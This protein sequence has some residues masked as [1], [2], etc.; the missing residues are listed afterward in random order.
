M[1]LRSLAERPFPLNHTLSIPLSD[2]RQAITR[3]SQRSETAHFLRSST[4]ASTEMRETRKLSNSDLE[5]LNEVH[6]SGLWT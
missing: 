2:L 3:P 4:V 6:V 1:S 5:R